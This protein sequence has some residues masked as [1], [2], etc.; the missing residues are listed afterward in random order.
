MTFLEFLAVTAS[1]LLAGGAGAAVVLYLSKK[2]LDQK[3]AQDLHG[4]STRYTRLD[5]QRTDAVLQ[6]HGLICEIE[7]MVIWAS[8][9]EGTA[10]ISTAPE[11]RTMEA[12]NKAWEEISKLTAVLNYHALLLDER[13]YE[14]VQD[15]SKHMMGTISAIGNEVEPARR[16]FGS[17]EVPLQEREARIAAVRD[18][19]LDRDLPRLGTIRKELEGRFRG[20]LGNES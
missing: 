10:V 4:F 18:R 3:L 5:K 19:V 12:L 8:G 13:I 20:V 9:P 16:R 17:T 7:H 1:S 14:L 6:L 11:Q 2:L 15:W